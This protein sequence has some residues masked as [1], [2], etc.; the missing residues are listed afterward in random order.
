MVAVFCSARS[1]PACK[2]DFNSFHAVRAVVADVV[3]CH[4]Y[5]LVLVK[6]PL[7]LCTAESLTVLIQ[8]LAHQ[9][10]SCSDPLHRY[11]L[12]LKRSV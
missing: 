6:Q 5:P 10:S 11:I 4:G 1:S 2:L 12:H 8:V 9:P 3:A 7:T